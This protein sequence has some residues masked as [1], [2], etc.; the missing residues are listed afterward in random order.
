MGDYVTFIPNY[1]GPY[2]SD[3]KIQ[4]SVEFGKAVPKDELDQLSRLHDSAYAHFGDDLHRTAADA[5]YNASAKDLAKA[6]PDVAGVLVLYGNKILDFAVNIY[7]KEKSLGFY[8][9]VLAGIQNEYKVIDYAL[10]GEQA[11]KDVL[12]YYQTDPERYNSLYNKQV[13]PKLGKV[14]DRIEVQAPISNYD[15]YTVNLGSQPLQYNPQNNPGKVSGT[16]VYDPFAFQYASDYRRK[17]KRRSH[18][19]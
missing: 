8:G 12:A 9:I 13:M 19:W 15:P 5:I 4:S 18:L 16:S 17:K 11:K 10:H 2:I 6:L 14:I 7:E 1:T 3:G